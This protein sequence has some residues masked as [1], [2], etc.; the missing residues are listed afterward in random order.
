MAIYPKIQ[1]P[2]PYAG[3]LSAF[4][5]GDLCRKCNRQVFDLSGMSDD[6]HIAFLS[7][8]QKE[9]CVTYKFSLK[10]VAAAAIAVT[11]LATPL[12]AAADPAGGDNVSDAEVVYVGAIHDPS[13]V[14]YTADPHAAATPDIPVVYETAFPAQA[15]NAAAQ[16]A[17]RQATTDRA[18]SADQSSVRAGSDLGHSVDHQ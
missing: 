3:E 12:T 6:G 14:S 7:A 5:D 10:T 11:A 17:T 4:M 15:S 13:N 8:C 1:S 9:V 2:C 16:P 18:A